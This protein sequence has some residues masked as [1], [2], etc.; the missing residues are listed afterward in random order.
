M[1]VSSIQYASGL[2]EKGAN[3]G[4]LEGRGLA[5]ASRGA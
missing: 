4:D 2:A 3:P 1:D 5:L